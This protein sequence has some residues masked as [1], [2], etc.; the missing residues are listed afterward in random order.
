MIA[1]SLLAYQRAFLAYDAVD[2][3]DS[4]ALAL[5]MDALDTAETAWRKDGCPIY[6]TPPVPGAERLASLIVHG[7]P[8]RPGPWIAED[9]PDEVWAAVRGVSNA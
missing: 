5:A 7:T 1:P 9:A 3:A 4:M 6:D 2:R 8:E